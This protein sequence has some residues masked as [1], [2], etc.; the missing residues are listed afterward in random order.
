MYKIDIVNNIHCFD[1]TLIMAAAV[2]VNSWYQ[3]SDVIPS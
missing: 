2:G 1:N 3:F